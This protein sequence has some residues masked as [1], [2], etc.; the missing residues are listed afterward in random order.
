MLLPLW[1]DTGE[2][3]L[4]LAAENLPELTAI[5]TVEPVPG[6]GLKV[7]VGE[8]RFKAGPLTVTIGTL[9]RRAADGWALQREII[10]LLPHVRG[11][12]HSLAGTLKLAGCTVAKRSLTGPY[13]PGGQIEI[14][15]EPKS[16][17][18]WQTEQGAGI[19]PGGPQPVTVDGVA[20]TPLRVA[21]TAGTAPI[22][23][24]RVLS[25]AG[26]TRWQGTVPAGQT[27]V[28][29]G[30]AGPRALLGG[31]DVSLY[32]LSPLPYLEP[33]ERTITVTAPGATC[34]AY[35]QEGTL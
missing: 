16:P 7:F 31:L 6:T 19:I 35:W 2:Q 20:R 4:G 13:E 23:D 22:T 27:L 30:G 25:D 34:T 5:G 29:D 10:G 3:R 18:F 14:A 8:R 26:E 1:R 17:Y 32:L 33:G 28:I 12:W 15:L 9:G 24:P 21:I 11:Y